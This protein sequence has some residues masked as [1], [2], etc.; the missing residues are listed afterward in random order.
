MKKILLPS[1]ILLLMAFKPAKVTPEAYN[2]SIINE[3][4]KIM[5]IML[6]MANYFSTDLNKAETLRQDLVKQCHASVKV[7]QA[8]PA[9]DGD[10]KFRDAGVAL[11]GFYAQIS[12]KEYKEM[13]D[14]LKKAEIE[15]A[16]IDRL[17]ALEQDITKR[18]VKFDEDFQ[19][20]QTAFAK[21][22]GFTLKENEYQKDVDQLG[23]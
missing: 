2:D 8:L 22:H 11:Y 6:E 23:K 10:T 1:V 5:K 7:L 3:Q 9:Y 17:T 13:I 21:K 12:D 20:A 4:N 18:E 15:Q 16:D 19:S 14:I